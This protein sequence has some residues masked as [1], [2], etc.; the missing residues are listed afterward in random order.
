MIKLG[1]LGFGTVGT[2]VYTVLKNNKESIRRKVG[3]E[4]EIKRILVND[5]EK[6]RSVDIS[7]DL[8]TDNVE[9]IINDPEIDLVVELIGGE[10]PAYTYIKRAINNKKSIVT[11]NKLVIARYEEELLELARKNGVSISFEGSVAGGIPII[12]PLKESFAANK[13][14]KI[15]GILNGT[16]NYILSKMTAEE[17]EFDEVLKEAQ[18]L[19]YAE[20]D[21]VSDISGADAAYKITILSSIAYETIVDI[22]DVYVEGVKGIEAEDIKNADELGYV[23]KLL[24]ISKNTGK[25]LDI[26]VHPAFVSKAHPLALV[27]D[28][29]N[30]IYLHG[31]AV[32]DVMLYGKGAGQMPT[33]SSVVADII[34]TAKE[35]FYKSP[36]LNNNN[37]IISHKIIDI[38]EVYNSFYIRLQ[39]VDKPGVLAKI[40]KVFGDNQVSLSSVIQKVHLEPAVPI[41]LVTHQVKESN[42]KRS[43]N[44]IKALD[45]VIGVKNIIRVEEI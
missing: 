32:G 21:P 6:K 44:E 35:I 23:I 5:L 37:T 30:A 25:G 28:V 31:D 40:A 2:G 1:L 14:E 26:R 19:G 11:A 20:S 38:S 22:E 3:T 16:T 33:A 17:L 24:A 42:L 18:K 9:D 41:V 13:I 8:L 10:E 4:L 15:Y 27:N 36:D 29:Y 7:R 12:R 39:V 34:Q 45:D 43:I